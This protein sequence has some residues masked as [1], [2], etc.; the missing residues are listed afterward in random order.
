MSSTRH[1]LYSPDKIA[2]LVF[3]TED[4]WCRFRADCGQEFNHPLSSR[5]AYAV[6]DIETDEFV[7][8]QGLGS[9]SADEMVPLYRVYLLRPLI[10][11]VS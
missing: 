9:F 2:G 6:V 4:G 3:A 1:D 5:H 7:G 8:I 10:Q 11:D